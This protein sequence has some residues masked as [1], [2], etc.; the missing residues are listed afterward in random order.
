M[1]VNYINVL[2]F[3]DG[4]GTT[5]E[6]PKGITEIGQKPS[7][8]LL[9][10]NYPNPFNPVTEISY[11]ILK[12]GFVSLKVYDMLGREVANLVSGVK[13]A[14]YYIANF[15]GENLSSGVYIYRLSIKLYD[16][17]KEFT[18]VKKLM[19]LK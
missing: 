19:L 5:K 9:N 11:Q 1:V 4:N 12:K 17:S 13:N 6:L 14:G 7:M 16:G 18:A 8:Y 15:N 2:A 3:S 10:Q